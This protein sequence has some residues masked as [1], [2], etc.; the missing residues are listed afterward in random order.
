MAITARSS[1]TCSRR[2]AS[3]GCDDA[4][5]GPIQ[6]FF[7]SRSITSCDARPAVYLWNRLWIFWCVAGRRRR[8][9]GARGL[10][11]ARLL[12]GDHDSAA[13]SERSKHE[14]IGE[15]NAGRRAHDD[16]VDHRAPCKAAQPEGQRR[17][18]GL[19]YCHTRR[20]WCAVKRLADRPEL[21]GGDAR[22]RVGVPCNARVLHFRA[23]FEGR[24]I[25]VSAT[26]IH[27]QFAVHQ[28]GLL[29]ACSC[30]RAAGNERP[31]H[32]PHLKDTSGI[33]TF[34]QCA[35]PC[36]SRD[37]A[38]AKYRHR[39][40]VGNDHDRIDHTRSFTRE[41]EIHSSILT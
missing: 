30:S 3:P 28:C 32:S 12:T 33:H 22:F 8:G 6:G 14:L 34:P 4:R 39:L 27:F 16:I 35:G 2:P 7:T 23:P 18:E 24:T 15:S 13:S 41:R 19:A 1:P 17:D 11:A 38:R 29:K 31:I 10:E 9:A 37:A 20:S 26:R 25:R 21:T 40:R 5:L 36:A